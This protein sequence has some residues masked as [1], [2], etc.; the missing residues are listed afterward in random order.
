MS[1]FIA[2]KLLVPCNTHG[3]HVIPAFLAAIDP[4]T[5]TLSWSADWCG[6]TLW[7]EIETTINVDIIRANKEYGHT[8]SS[9]EVV[10][11]ADFA[12]L[13]WRSI[14]MII[15]KV[16]EGKIALSWLLR[17]ANIGIKL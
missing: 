12:A 9:L 2:C 7:S 16:A 8:M 14:A 1:N 3:Y 11:E 10:R 4:K 13:A 5:K 6:A 17:N 15:P